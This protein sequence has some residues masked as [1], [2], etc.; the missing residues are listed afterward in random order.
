[1][2][3]ICGQMHLQLGRKGK[4]RSLR[5]AHRKSAADKVAGF[6]GSAAQG[7]KLWRPPLNIPAVCVHPIGGHKTIGV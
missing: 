7:R 4:K 3:G 1:M 5:S 2:A 6:G